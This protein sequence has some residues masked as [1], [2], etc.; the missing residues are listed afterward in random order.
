MIKRLNEIVG[1]VR[2]DLEPVL[3][4]TLE[5]MIVAGMLERD[6]VEQLVAQ[7]VENAEDFAWT[8]QLRYY[9]CV[10]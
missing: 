6:V 7:S 5:A 1:Q 10:F 8:S 9:L 4:L 2:G 3:R